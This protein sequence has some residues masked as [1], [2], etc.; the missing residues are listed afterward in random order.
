MNIV[1]ATAEFTAGLQNIERAIIA[2]VRD[3]GG[4]ITARN[5]KWNQGRYLVPPPRDAIE[6]EI[7]AQG[8]TFNARL[9]FEQVKDSWQRIERP[10]V[11]AGVRNAVAALTH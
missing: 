8:R 5:F 11:I 10:D 1:Q 4:T 3:A 7:A 6:L 2:K 9:S